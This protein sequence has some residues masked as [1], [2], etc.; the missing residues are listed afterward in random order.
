MG[1]LT[2]MR[3]GPDGP[4]PL[5]IVDQGL[6][7]GPN[8]AERRGP[9]EHVYPSVSALLS[10]GLTPVTTAMISEPPAAAPG[11]RLELSA[12]RAA[13]LSAPDGSISWAGECGQPRP[14][15]ELITRTG[16]CAVLIGAIGLW[17]GSGARAPTR[18][19]TRLDQAAQAGELAGGLVAAR[20]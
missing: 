9:G 8:L 6:G 12:L 1:A 10:M 2:D 13:R 3:P 18:I 4:L 7:Q 17:P 20:C 15:R 5:L 16:R 11:W 19:E 14:W